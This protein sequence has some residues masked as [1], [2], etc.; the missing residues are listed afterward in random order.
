MNKNTAGGE[1]PA[2]FLWLPPGLRPPVPVPVEHERVLLLVGAATIFSGYDFNIFGM[3]LPQIQ[4]ELN[5]P[6][7]EA[8][9]TIAYFRLAAIPALLLALTADIFGR[10]RLLLITMVGAAIGTF[11]TAFVR[12]HPEFIWIQ[13][14]VRIFGY[15]EEM[16]AFV[17]IAEV[18]APR[19]RGWSIGAMGALAAFGGGLA[20]IVFGLVN[21][22]PYGWRAIYV[23]GAGPLLL[24]AYFRRRLPETPRFE[25]RE[26]EVAML[27]SRTRAGL[28]ALRQLATQY[29]ARVAALYFTVA[30]FGFAMGPATTLMSKYLQQAHGYAPPEV[31]I[32][33][34]FGGALALAGNFLAGR[35]S[36]RLGRKATVLGCALLAGGGYALFYSGIGGWVLPLAWILGIMGYLSA[37]A[38]LSGFPSEIFPTA[39][40]ATA[41]GMRYLVAILFGALGLS[42]EGTFYDW[43]VAQGFAA[44]LA[45][46]P[47]ILVPLALVPLAVGAVLMLP[48]TSGRTLEELTETRA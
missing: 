5:I 14:F 16:L 34:L 33:F 4:A 44:D 42:L 39:Y 13:L 36:D 37:E 23:L 1:R 46:G 9:L 15:A 38:L 28:E 45:H 17:V 29:P 31:T 22:L 25:A 11:L 24:V 7:N 30:C 10:R 21:F 12:T 18:V 47:A 2:R 27:A 32:L 3:A 26:R 19:I 40:R 43:F 48:E 35:I 20:A 6:E 8:A 41:S